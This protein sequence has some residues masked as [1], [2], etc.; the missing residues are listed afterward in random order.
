MPAM[1]RLLSLIGRLQAPMAQQI[2]QHIFDHV[3]DDAG[4]LESH[5]R[6]AGGQ[7]RPLQ[8]VVGAMA[9]IHD[10]AEIGHALED[11]GR[12]EVEIEGRHADL[13][14]VADLGPDAKVEAGNRR[15]H[16][17][18]P[19]V[20]VFQRADKGEGHGVDSGCAQGSAVAAG[21]GVGATRTTIHKPTRMMPPPISTEGVSCSP[22]A[23]AP[24]TTPATG[25]NR[26]NG[27]T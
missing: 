11:A 7:V 24:V 5:H 26:T 12:H 23:R 25:I 16:L 13:S 21:A 15:R 20:G 6:H 22:S 17:P 4:V 9:E 14:F 8:E 3:A 1:F 2:Q 19:E 18:P 27:V 10:A